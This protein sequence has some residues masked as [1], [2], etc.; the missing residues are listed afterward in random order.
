MDRTDNCQ[1]CAARRIEDGITHCDY[2]GIRLTDDQ[3][4]NYPPC[5]K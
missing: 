2:L 3:E 5:I 4:S 1:H